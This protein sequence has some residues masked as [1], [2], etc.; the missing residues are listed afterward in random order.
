MNMDDRDISSMLKDQGFHPRQ[1]RLMKDRDSGKSKGAAFVEFDREEDAKDVCRDLDG[2]TS[3]GRRL[4][5]NMA[6]SKR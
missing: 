4:K 6:D 2:K 5:V 1:V 3:N